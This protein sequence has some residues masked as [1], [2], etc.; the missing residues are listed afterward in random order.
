MHLA[1]GDDIDPRQFLIQ[2]SRLGASMLGVDHG[3]HG[4]LSDGDERSSDSYQ[5]GTLWAP[6]TVV[7]YFE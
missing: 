6:I 4:D 3:T 1:S 7:A 5:S 2:T